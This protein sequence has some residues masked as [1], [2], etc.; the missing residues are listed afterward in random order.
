MRAGSLALL[1]AALAG[2][3]TTAAAQ[4][5]SRRAPD[6]GAI[7]RDDKGTRVVMLGTGT[8]NADPDRSG[9]AVAVVVNET[10]YLV[11]AGPGIV[12]RAA[13][14]QRNGIDALTVKRLGI[15]FI[16]HLHSDHTLGLPDLIFSP[17]VLERTRPLEVFGPPGIKAMTEHLTAAW[18]EDVRVRI[19]GLEPANETGYRVRA[20]EISPGVV[21][22]DSN[23]T[24]RAF[25]VPHGDWK[26]AF[27]YRFET[28]DRTIVISGDTRPS[29]A[30]VKAC[31]G[32]DILVHE[33]YSS[34]KFAT[35]PAEWQRYHASAHT[36]T[37][38]L[39]HLADRARPGLLVLYHQLYWGA[40]D[41]DLLREV[42][43]IYSGRVSSARDLDVFR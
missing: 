42:R 5:T 13:A 24:V 12:R 35:R 4:D 22:R 28:R 7:V 10:A 38:E 9:P 6:H 30:I 27:G 25:S 32:C 1:C 43:R 23:V 39:A 19:D 36:S 18:R 15:V 29:D 37:T 33:V 21:Y 41:D 40:S 20:H 26:Y 16:T 31:N 14:A 11:D 3:A 8:P 34:E 17:W 2:P